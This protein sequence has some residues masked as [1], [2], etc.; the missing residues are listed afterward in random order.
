MVFHILLSFLFY[1]CLLYNVWK[2]YSK[3]DYYIGKKSII[4]YVLLFI[5]FGTYGGGEGDYIH[6]KQIVESFQDLSDVFFRQG[7]EI[8]YNYLAYYVGGNYT[9]WRLAI[10]SVQFIGLGWFLYKAKMNTYTF[11]ICFISLSL[12]SSVYGRSVWGVIYFY[13]G[14]YLFVE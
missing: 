3:G 9:L 1:N 8:Q 10:Y 13:M 14:I 11:L 2:H 12:V 6:L 5:S 7:M 4:I